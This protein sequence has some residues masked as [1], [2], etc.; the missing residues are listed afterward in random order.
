M[1]FFSKAPSKP[2]QP[3]LTAQEQSAQDEL[4]RLKLAEETKRIALETTTERKTKAKTLIQ[5]TAGVG[6]R[7]DGVVE[8]HDTFNRKGTTPST[9]KQGDVV[10]DVHA[11]K[12]E[13]AGNL[14]KFSEKGKSS[15]HSTAGALRHDLKEKFE[16]SPSKDV[17]ALFKA[18]KLSSD[19]QS[20]ENSAPSYA[21]EF[22]EIEEQV[23]TMVGEEKHIT[24][25][26][27]DL[28]GRRVTKTKIVLPKQQAATVS[29]N[30][31]KPS[32]SSGPSVPAGESGGYVSIVDLRQN[33][34]QGID[35]HNKE[36]Y[37]SPEEF[38]KAF[39]MTKDE[40][41]KLP[42]WKRDKLKRELYLF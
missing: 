12:N 26:G 39:K 31:Q 8:S 7:K 38:Q 18:K 42:K 1:G 15:A 27:L 19:S 29:Q 32:A 33:R 4:A 16:S 17:P 3:K 35:K 36:K 22:S 34:A 25:T 6:T 10:G 14:Q 13:Y 37:L 5:N 30:Q 40:F 20:T 9:L 23:I 11:K 41:E 28:Q 2:S 21:S 24:T